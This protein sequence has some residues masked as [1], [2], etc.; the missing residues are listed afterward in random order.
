MKTFLR[1]I[2]THPSILI[3]LLIIVL[4]VAETLP[5][6]WSL[7]LAIVVALCSFVALVLANKEAQRDE[8]TI[9]QQMDSIYWKTP[10]G[11]QKQAL[12]QLR[13]PMRKSKE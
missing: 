5:Y 13:A 9:Q 2:K 7:I 4:A 1:R 8:M 12:E 6:R 10:E 3:S 11:R